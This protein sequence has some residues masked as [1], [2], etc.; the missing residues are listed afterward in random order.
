MSWLP[1]RATRTDAEPR[2]PARP[3][4]LVALALGSFF[5][6]A[7]LVRALVPWP[8]EYG[9]RA[10]FEHFRAHKDEFDAIYL[11]SSRYFRS[12]DPTVIDA[13]F[14]AR[15]IELRSFN[16]GVGGM[17]SFEMDHVLREI[18]ALRPARLKW[19]FFEGGPWD[20]T[21]FFIGNT[22]ST[23]SIHWHD[24]AGTR[25]VLRSIAV[26][27]LPFL[28]KL[29]LYW[30]HL[31][32][33][34]MKVTS[35]AQSPRL[36]AAALGSTEDP[37]KRAL[38]PEDLEIR[39]G[40][41][42]L[43]EL[44]DVEAQDWRQTLVDDPTRFERAVAAIPAWNSAPLDVEHYD[45]AAL[46]AQLDLVRS[47]GA[48]LVF[49]IPP[50]NEGA[51]DRLRLHERGDIEDLIDFNSPE[52]YPQFFRYENRFDERHLN[53]AGAREFSRLFAAEAARVLAS[54]R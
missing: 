40:F 1:R 32:L 11:G 26:A 36:V 33:H 12:F 28:R 31:R 53:R 47:I 5:S 15:G 35:M 24:V 4:F 20:P 19:I 29:D 2:S 50:Q 46:R 10:K 21:I 17:V 51:A 38:S 22:W 25:T 16:F 48:R 23:R 27:D 13:E 41:Q 49:V 39:R 30:T 37:L 9:L 6:V 14:A 45:F 52:R 43:D 3:V 8:E 7:A 34:G 42:A 18:V 44:V 54:A